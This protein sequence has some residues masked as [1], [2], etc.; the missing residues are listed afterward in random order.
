MVRIKGFLHGLNIGK[1]QY[2]S[3]DFSLDYPNIVAIPDN[4]QSET[5]GGWDVRI[6]LRHDL[7]ETK[8][9][10]LILGKSKMNCGYLYE[11]NNWGGELT[12]PAF[13][14]FKAVPCWVVEPLDGLN[15][16][17]PYYVLEEDIIVEAVT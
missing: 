14:L 11:G 7:G 1:D 17:K 6:V 2:G 9:K 13:D 5:S 3:K 10:F 15:Y 4:L 16:V 12:R 8:G